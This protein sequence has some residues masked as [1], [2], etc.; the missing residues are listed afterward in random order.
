MYTKHVSDS[1]SETCQQLKYAD[2]IVSNAIL[3]SY[4]L[5]FNIYLVYFCF[6]H[7]TNLRNCIVKNNSRIRILFVSNHIT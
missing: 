5:V 6:V 1:Y 2:L 4:T 7:R 3:S